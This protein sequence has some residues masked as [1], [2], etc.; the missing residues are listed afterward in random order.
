MTMQD[1]VMKLIG[2]IIPVGVTEIDE[3]R[4]NN[5]VALTEVLNGLITEV[6]SLAT[7]R[8]NYQYSVSRAGKHAQKFL[9]KLKDDLSEDE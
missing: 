1:V 6:K 5:L 3:E 9:D 2:K 4:F 7:Y 8:N